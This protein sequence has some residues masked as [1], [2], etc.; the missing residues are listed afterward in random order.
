MEGDVKDL[1]KL[2]KAIL[3]SINQLNIF[4]SE[5]LLVNK[6]YVLLSLYLGGLVM[7]LI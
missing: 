4:E 7:K 1:R 5:N 2:G 3:Y 6:K